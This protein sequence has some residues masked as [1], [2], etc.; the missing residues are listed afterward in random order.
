MYFF[1]FFFAGFPVWICLFVFCFAVLFWQIF[2][3]FIKNNCVFLLFLSGL[4][5]LFCRGFYLF[6]FWFAVLSPFFCFCFVLLVFS[7]FSLFGWDAWLTCLFVCFRVL[8]GISALPNPRAS[9]VT[10]NWNSSIAS[11][12]RRGLPQKHSWHSIT[13]FFLYCI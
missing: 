12:P 7:C 5:V 8:S 9:P 6:L 10:Q 2:A 13:D 3:V 11:Q 1:F 4:F